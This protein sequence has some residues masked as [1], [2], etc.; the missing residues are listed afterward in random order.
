[1]SAICALIREFNWTIDE[2]VN[3]NWSQIEALNKGLGELNTFTQ[4][5]KPVEEKSWQEL[6]QDDKYQKELGERLAKLKA[7]NGG[8]IDA[9]E[10]YKF[11][12]GR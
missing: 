10:M 7:A 6:A 2:V 5:N 8:K 4:K 11:M 1:M 9:R 3:L 12:K